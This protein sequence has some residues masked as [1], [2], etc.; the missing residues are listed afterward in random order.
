[1]KANNRIKNGGNVKVKVQN[2]T[3][4]NLTEILPTR[5]LSGVCIVKEKP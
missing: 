4:W 3:R 5:Y 2:P 1:M